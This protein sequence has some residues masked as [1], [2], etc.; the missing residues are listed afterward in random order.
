MAR[1]RYPRSVRTRSQK[2]RFTRALKAEIAKGHT[3]RY[4][5]R[6]AAG[7][8]KGQ[9]KQQARGH[10]EEGEHRR[11][12]ERERESA[13]ISSDQLKGIRA[14]LRRFNPKEYKDVPDEEMLVEFVQERDYAAFQAYRT[15]WDKYRREWL[16]AKLAGTLDKNGSLGYSLEAITGESGVPPQGEERWL[17]YH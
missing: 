9:T 11:R 8:A 15:T 4:A 1:T 3:E 6:V 13:G 5:K 2:V 7:A 16:S 10:K 17:Y 12:A 14:F